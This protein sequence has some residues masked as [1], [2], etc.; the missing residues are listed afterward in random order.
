VLPHAQARSEP[1]AAD[2][3]RAL[4]GQN[5]AERIAFI[6]RLTNVE[7]CRGGDGGG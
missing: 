5:I 6:R 2:D 3:P 1:E 7:S 4:I